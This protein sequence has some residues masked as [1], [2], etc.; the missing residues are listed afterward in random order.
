MVDITVLMDDR[1]EALRPR[2]L[3]AEHGFSVVV[4][5]ILF[6]TGESGAA[7]ANARRL[8]L[9]T[10]YDTIVL[11]HGHYDHTGG[12]SAF[13]PEAETLYVHPDAFESKFREDDYIGNPYRRDRIAADVDVTTHTD[14]VEVAPDIYALG[15]IPRS[16]PDNPTGVTVDADGKRVTDRIRDDQS[17]AIDTDDGVFLICG[18][19]HAGLRNTIEHAETVLDGP[20]RAV[21]GGTHLTAVDEETVHEIA[22]WL[23]GRLDLLAPSH[24]TGPAAKRI[25][26]DRFPAA[27]M[28]VGVGSEIDW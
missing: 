5:G 11:S 12:L 22:D 8:G 2:A 21:L 6:D 10:A 17:L 1:I 4:D 15:E 16:Y 27:F 26:A 9:P 3:Q 28:E 25:L 18:C 13:L 7:V 20:V 23:E 14:P 19:C 24:C